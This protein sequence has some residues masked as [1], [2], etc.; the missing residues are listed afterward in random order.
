MESI[1][2]CLVSISSDH[3]QHGDHD[4]EHRSFGGQAFGLLESHARE[5]E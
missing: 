3:R 4:D 5:D 2:V 1:L